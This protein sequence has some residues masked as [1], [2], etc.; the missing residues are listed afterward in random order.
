MNFPLRKILVPT[1]F[2]DCAARALDQALVLARQSGA[3]VHL[4][5]VMMAYEEDPYSLVYQLPDRHELYLQQ[6]KACGEQMAE[7]LTERG[8]ADS[9]VQHRVRA[10]AIAP[11]IA[12][13]AKEEGMDLVVMGGHGRRGWRR[14]LLGSVTEEVVRIAPCPVLTVREQVPQAD[15]L[16]APRIL[17]PV[18]FSQQARH[19]LGVARDLAPAEGTLELLHV[20]EHPVYPQFYDPSAGQILFPQLLPR[21]R[22]ALGE[23]A[24]GVLGDRQWTCRIIEGNAAH[25]IAESAREGEIDLIIMATHGLTGLDHFLLGSV[26]ERVVREAPCP[27]LI[28]KMPKD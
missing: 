12:R 14:F 7:L 1:D 18:D 20:T 4:L 13:F 5:Y 16:E 22:E 15:R 9:V 6:E 11:E 23:L 25:Q 24:E 27:V 17:V 28:L 19:A 26:T 10:L 3:E 2:S 8:V 21:I